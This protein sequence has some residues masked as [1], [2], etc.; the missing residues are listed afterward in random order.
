[1][2]IWDSLAN[3]H[4]GRYPGTNLQDLNRV[5]MRSLFLYMP[6]LEAAVKKNWTQICYLWAVKSDSCL[7]EPFI[8][9][10][11]IQMHN[12]ILEEFIHFCLEQRLWEWTWFW[13]QAVISLR[14]RG[15]CGHFW[16]RLP[17]F[18]SV[19]SYMPSLSHCSYSR[20]KLSLSWSNVSIK[21]I[22]WESRSIT[23]LCCTNLSCTFQTLLRIYSD[24]LTMI[25]V[26]C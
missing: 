3:A 23:W 5:R 9:S 6:V 14:G 22:L 12:K 10:T 26:Y 15:K 24:V 16:G 17:I 4:I 20:V 11:S 19:P 8:P 13:V 21:N 2:Y 7:C 25:E 18:L 1:M